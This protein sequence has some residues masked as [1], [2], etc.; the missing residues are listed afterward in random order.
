MDISGGHWQR[1]NLLKLAAQ[2]CW[3]GL[4]SFPERI[5]RTVYGH[6]LHLKDAVALVCNV[7]IAGDDRLLD[8]TRGCRRVQECQR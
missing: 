1:G 4:F 8:L 7:Q 3:P 5:G 6:I 2:C